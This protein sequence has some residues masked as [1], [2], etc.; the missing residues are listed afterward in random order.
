[1]LR[2]ELAMA[3]MMVCRIQCV[4]YVLNRKPRRQLNFSAARI[5]PIT[6]SCIRSSIGRPRP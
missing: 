3:R 5:R 4:A 2:P 1:M 6:P